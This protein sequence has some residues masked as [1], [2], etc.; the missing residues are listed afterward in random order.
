MGTP[1][2]HKDFT[3]SRLLGSDGLHLV[4]IHCRY[5]KRTTHYHPE[6]LIYVFGDVDIDSL[7]RRMKCEN[8]DHS[9]LDVGTVIPSGRDAVGIRLR[10]LVGFRIKRVPVWREG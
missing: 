7:A 9:V 5:C 2:A 6:D 3:L 4:R 1:L 10:R 8:G